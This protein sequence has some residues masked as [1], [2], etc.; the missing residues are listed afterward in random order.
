MGRRAVRVIDFISEQLRLELPGQQKGRDDF[1]SRSSR[2]LP[3][4]ATKD[5]ISICIYAFMSFDLSL[6]LIILQEVEDIS[7]GV[8]CIA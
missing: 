6:R 2:L 5:R 7:K 4:I 3:R 8:V 1:A